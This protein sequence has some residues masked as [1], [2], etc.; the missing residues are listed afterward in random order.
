M[1]LTSPY[2]LPPLLRRMGA[3]RR[4]QDVWSA[5][6]A[7]LPVYA[8]DRSTADYG[9]NGGRSRIRTPVPVGSLVFKTS[10]FPL[11]QPSKVVLYADFNRF[12]PKSR[13]RPV[14]AGLEPEW[15]PTLAMLQV[16]LVCRTNAL[17]IELVGRANGLAGGT[18]TLVPILRRDRLVYLAARWTPQWDSNPQPTR[19]KRVARSLCFEGRVARRAGV[20]PASACFGGRDSRLNYRREYGPPPRNRTPI[21][22]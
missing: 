22:R 3:Q 17:L 11:C 21:P 4:A 6:P 8:M 9:P 19:S 20:Q 15:C 1:A 16:P 5:V 18:C 2:L 10:A 13:G 7:S 12:H 14:M